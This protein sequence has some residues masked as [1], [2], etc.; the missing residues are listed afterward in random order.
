MKSAHS[1]GNRIFRAS[2]ICFICSLTCLSAEQFGDFTYIDNGTSITITDYPSN[3]VGAVEIPASINGLPV[4][5][6]G[7][8]AF[9]NCSGLT[10]VTIPEGVTSIRDE[11]FYRSGLT[12]VVIPSS[13]ASIGVWAFRSCSGLTAIT[14]DAANTEYGSLDGV[15]FN[16]SQSTLIQYPGGI[17]G[18]Y[19]IPEG[20]TSIG[21]WAFSGCDSLTSVTIPEGLTSIGGGAFFYCSGLTV[22]TVD[23]ANTE[24]GS[25]NGVLF[26]KSQST[27]IQYPAGMSGSYTIPS[28]VTSIED[29]AFYACVD[30]TSV[31]IP[32]SVASIGGSAFYA[33]SGLRSAFFQGDAPALGSNVFLNAGAGF[34]VYCPNGS[35]GFTSPT[36]EGYPSVGI[37]QSVHPAATWLLTHNLPYD[38]ALDQDLN[39]D[40]VSL[41]MAYALN[42]DPNLNLAG[43][44]PRAVLGANTIGIEFYAGT[45][46]II[47]SV[48]TSTDLEEWMTDGVVFS[49][50]DPDG[51]RTATVTRG[52]SGRFLRL[53]VMQGP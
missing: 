13:V 18:S 43:G 50:I 27:L 42:L 23:A 31:T 30:L 33:C 38:T 40:G 29:S 39:G 5:S 24:Y 28:S 26:D 19:T 44:M 2:L 46:G 49:D 35:A 47:Y 25:L 6:I 48:E 7:D 52:S 36:W 15:L 14:V 32:S 12:S 4:T 20:V 45:P 17:S 21:Y 8:E 34:T 3:A 53:V 41:L 10:S 16:K 1:A 22:I 9:V 51:Q 11:A 37:D